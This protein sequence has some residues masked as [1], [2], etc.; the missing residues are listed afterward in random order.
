MI[1]Q[2]KIEQK[3]KDVFSPSYLEVINES[4]MHNVPAGSESHFK[5]IVVSESFEGQRL[6]SRHRA[7]NTTLADELQNHIHALAMHTYTDIEWQKEKGIAP[8]SP[9]CLG[10]NKR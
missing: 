8:D 5:V 9:N 1:I 6:I 7:I 2:Q 4:H 3:L 10:G